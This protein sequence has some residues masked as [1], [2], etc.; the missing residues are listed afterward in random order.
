[1]SCGLAVPA[2]APAHDIPTTVVVRVFVKPD[3]DR[4]RVLVRAPLEAMRDIQWPVRGPGYVELDRAEPL[5]GDAVRLWIAGSME[6]QENG[7]RL[8]GERILAARVSLPSDGSFA[9]YA[10]ALAHVTGPPLPVTTELM[11]QQALLDVLLDY[12]ITSEQSRFAMRPT[13][14]RLGLRTTTVLR[15]L[16]PGRPERAFQYVGDPGL[17]RLD[18]RW[19]QAALA[20]VKLGFLHILEGM[21]H[22]LFVVC[23]VIPFRRV[24]PVLAI[25]TSFTL[26]HSITL[27]ASAL[28]LSPRAL[29]FPPLIEA[30]IALSILYMAVENIVGARLHRRWLVAF[31]F[32]LVH[33]FGFSFALQESLQ[34]AGAHLVTSLL[35]FNLGVELGQVVVLLAAIPLLEAMFRRVVAERLGTIL[36]S[37]LVAHTAWHWMTERVTSLGQYQFRWPALDLALA[38][39]FLRGLMVAVMLGGVLWGLSGLVRRLVPGEARAPAGAPNPDARSA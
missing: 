8:S 3:G 1:M 6:L 13:L 34:F 24:R 30:L 27:M 28:G 15:F 2:A 35:T 12:P 23:L 9:E 11:W 36:L 38:V 20:F 29:W 37:A 14:A 26:A 25:V 17:V 5:L 19:H 21:D 16:A 7:V 33:G 22:L 32:G 31:G 18:P 39:G 10:T 4:L